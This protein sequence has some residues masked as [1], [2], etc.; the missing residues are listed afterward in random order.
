M[1]PRRSGGDLAGGLILVGLGVVFLLLNF[2][3]LESFDLGRWWP[4]I[5]IVIGLGMLLGRRSVTP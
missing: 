2:G 4:A 3:Y 5:L 1:E